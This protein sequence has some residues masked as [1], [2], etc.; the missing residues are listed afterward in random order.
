MAVKNTHIMLNAFKKKARFRS[1]LLI[2]LFAAGLFCACS[3]SQEIQVGVFRKT[4]YCG[5]SDNRAISV[6][7]K[8]SSPQPGKDTP[9]GGNFKEKRR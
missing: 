4:D 7:E 1:G 8:K 9:I 5:S 2:A 3:S 6:L